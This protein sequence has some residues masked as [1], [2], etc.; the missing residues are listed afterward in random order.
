MSGATARGTRK[1]QQLGSLPQLSHGI[2]ST[3]CADADLY[4][5]YEINIINLKESVHTRQQYGVVCQ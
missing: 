3:L 5:V 2:Q 1:R 4:I